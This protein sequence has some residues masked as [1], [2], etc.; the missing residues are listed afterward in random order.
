MQK[1]IFFVCIC[2]G[3]ELQPK[4]E[5]GYLKLLL[6]F[7]FIFTSAQLSHKWEWT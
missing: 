6:K 3:F 5:L 7:L 1:G 4:Y 2:K